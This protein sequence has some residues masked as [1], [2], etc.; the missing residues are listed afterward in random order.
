MA[1]RFLVTGG[2]G[3][4]GSHLVAALVERGDTVVV[5]DNLRTGHRGAVPPGVQLIVADLAD[6]GN[7]RCA[8]GRWSVARG[9]PLRRAVAGGREHAAAVPLPDRQRRQRHAPDRGLRAPWR[10]ALRAVL[11]RG[12]VRHAEDRA[13]PG[14]RAA[15]SG[16]A[17]RRQQV[18]PRAHAALGGARAWAALCVAA[19]L[20][21]RRR[22][23]GGTLWRGSSAGDA[24]RPAGDRRGA[25]PRARN[26]TCTATTMPRRTAPACATTCT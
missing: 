4:V 1:R 24:S 16:I 8:A 18:V 15:R 26:S 20:Q 19:L 2:A 9:V 6:A 22:R 13:D 12:A 11:D 3:Y 25:R 14:R 10:H 17:L 5:L 23:S 21:R 7:G